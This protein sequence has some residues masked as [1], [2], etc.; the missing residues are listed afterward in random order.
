MKSLKASIAEL[1]KDV[2]YLKSTD[3][4]MVF[5][6]VEILHVPEM[7]LTTTRHKDKIKKATD[8]ESDA[9]TN[10]EMFEETEVTVDED[11]I[12]TE[13]VMIDADVQDF[14]ANAPDPGS[15]GGAGRS[16]VTSS[17]EAQ[18]QAMH[19]ELRPRQ[20][21]RLHKHDLLFTSFSILF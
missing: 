5:G 21:E 8:P 3:I 1:R 4:S 18:V 20:I 7:P 6:I 19:R 12:A 16:E 11:L 13:A 17:T 2:D 15:G 10:E 9:D 14:L